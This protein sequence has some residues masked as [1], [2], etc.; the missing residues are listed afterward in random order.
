[1]P[2][3]DIFNRNQQSLEWFDVH[4]NLLAKRGNIKFVPRAKLGVQ[5]M[6][7]PPV[8]AFT[9]SVF[10]DEPNAGSPA[11][12]GYIRASQTTQTIQT[13]QRQLLLGLAMGGWHHN[14]AGR[15]GGAMADPNCS[16]TGG[17]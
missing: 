3:R 8:R 15:S 12:T 17:I 9:V 16:A 5:T 2:W 7:D 14:F 13:A 6:A 4:G 1:M 11:L 10:E